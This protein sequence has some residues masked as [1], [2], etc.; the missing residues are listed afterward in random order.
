[1]VRFELRC[2]CLVYEISQSAN[3]CPAVDKLS[4][5]AA[6][7]SNG[8]PTYCDSRYYRA[9]AGGGQGCD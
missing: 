2:C 9:I 7:E 5:I 6:K 3:D 1:M 4:D 8:R